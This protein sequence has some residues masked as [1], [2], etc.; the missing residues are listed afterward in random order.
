MSKTVEGRRTPLVVDRTLDLAFIIMYVIFALWALISSV[1]NI[2]SFD[3]VSTTLYQFIYGGAVGTFAAIAA[4]A[5]ILQFFRTGGVRKD[6]KEKIELYAVVLA[7]GFIFVY[8]CVL[9]FN[10]FI[11]HAKGVEAGFVLSLYYVLFPL[12]RIRHLWKRIKLHV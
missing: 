1:E 11:L 9:A 8:P 4:T 7:T 5:A 3:R 12:W 6:H 2:P 10:L